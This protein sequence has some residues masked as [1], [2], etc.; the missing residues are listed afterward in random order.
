M[1]MVWYGPLTSYIYTVVRKK[2]TPGP[3]NHLVGFLQNNVVILGKKRASYAYLGELSS[4]GGD[5]I[6][7]PESIFV[8]SRRPSSL[9]SRIRSP[10][11]PS[12]R[13]FRS[14]VSHGE[15]ESQ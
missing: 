14:S 6:R 10:D 13:Y 15:P 9:D 5:G 12:F 7:A 11:F 4:V 1:D 8:V 3:W 2:E